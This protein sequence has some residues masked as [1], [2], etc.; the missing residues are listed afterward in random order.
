MQQRK[1]KKLIFYFFLLILLGSINN[2]RL[3]EVSLKEI[4]NI[5]IYGLDD[6]DKRILTTNIQNLNLSN[7]FF[8]NKNELTK[9]VDNNTL[10]ENY[11]IFKKYPSTID[12]K[13]K[14]TNFLAKINIEGKTFLVGSNGKLTKQNLLIYELPY[15]FGKPEIY[16]FIKFKKVIDQSKIS[17][18]QVKNIY[19][20]NSKRWD[21]ELND[22]TLIKLPKN[23]VHKSLDNI[24]DIMNNDN[25]K[26]IKFIDVRVA[27]Q[28]IIN[29]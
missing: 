27:N 15:I 24:F 21:L 22:G 1:S 13:I 3:D 18:N 6:V 7:I 25:L 28:I 10:V 16:E 2:L 20:F 23:N 14:K 5:N 26:N 19:Y 9:I 29:D 17:F 11:S 4:K 12:I 8:I